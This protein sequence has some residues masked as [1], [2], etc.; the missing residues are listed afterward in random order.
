VIGTARKGR[1]CI[2][3]LKMWADAEVELL[4]SARDDGLTARECAERLGRTPSAVE[5][6][7]KSRRFRAG[8]PTA[9]RTDARR[10][11]MFELYPSDIHPAELLARINALPGAQIKKQNAL[12]VWAHTLGLS[13]PNIGHPGKWTPARDA[14]LR[15]LVAQGL[16]NSKIL[17]QINAL[18]GEGFA[19]P[20]A[21]SRRIQL[22]KLER[23]KPGAG[24]EVAK[25]AAWSEEAVAFLR[26]NIATMQQRQ[27]AAA[28]GKSMFSV[29]AKI[30]R[31]GLTLPPGQ[32][33]A[34]TMPQVPK[35]V[36]MPKPKKEPPPPPVRKEVRWRGVRDIALWFYRES[37]AE[38]AGKPFEAFPDMQKVNAL[39]HRLGKPYVFAVIG[40]K[41][42]TGR[43]A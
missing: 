34:M 16:Q 42:T 25:E 22:L 13:R 9:Q 8:G 23:P 11:L 31:L 29:K 28:L 12:A 20:K 40:G 21:M 1:G 19:I 32:R 24:S 27:I 4:R 26:D 37:G 15:E 33:S 10:A 6:M 36:R 3:D 30:A 14:L 5:A 2:R 17:P 43:A 35:V 39:C 41:F 38:A 18:P 7:L